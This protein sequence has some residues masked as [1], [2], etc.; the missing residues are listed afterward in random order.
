MK[1][2]PF[3]GTDADP[4]ERMHWV[5]VPFS[6]IL[7]LYNAQVLKVQRHH[8]RRAKSSPHLTASDIPVHV[9]FTA[10]RTP[11]NKLKLVD[12]YTRITAIVNGDKPAP[13][14]AWLGVVDCANSAEVEK[15]YDAMDSRQ[16]VK[17]GRDAFDEG[18]RRA[19]LL[20]KVE[21]PV[22]VRG[23]AVSAIAAA[24]GTN[25][26]RKATW[27][28]RHGIAALDK[29]HIRSGRRGLPSGALAGLLVL[30]SNEEDTPRVQRFAAALEHPDNV[31]DEVRKEQAGAIKCAVQLT[32][33]REQGALSGKNVVPIMELVLGYWNWQ[34]KGAKG[35]ASSMSRADYLESK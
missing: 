23:Q 12:G 31:P 5:Q 9:N 34:N 33:R 21:S 15:L 28:L 6:D 11:D 10:G 27:E 20:S 25:D 2:P 3:A 7:D 8:I 18:M 1:L 30:A 17:R 13:K 29:L 32:E 19:G 4:E 14:K 22:F 26:I 16:A 24:A 35:Y